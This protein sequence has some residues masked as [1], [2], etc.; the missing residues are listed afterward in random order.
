[1]I[2]IMK[3]IFNSLLLFAAVVGFTS[4]NDTMDD[5]AVIDAMYA[6]ASDV[7]VENVV[8][9]AVDYQTISATATVSA[10]EGLLEVGVEYAT[11]A[12]FSDAEA[13]P[14]A[15]LGTAVSVTATGLNG[16][17]EYFVRAYAVT[18]NAGTVVS[19]SVTVK[20]PKIPI[21]DVNGMYTVTEYSQS[22]DDGLF[23]PAAE[24]YP[25]LVQFLEGSE[26][27]VE[28]INLWGFGGTIYGTWDAENSVIIVPTKQVLGVH[29]SYGDVWA[30]A[31]NASATAY[32]QNIIFSFT[33]IG[34]KMTCTPFQ[35]Q[36]GAGDFG[37]YYVSMV[38]NE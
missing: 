35:A 34:G 23:Y 21:F 31:L 30:N 28:I 38:H 12:D 16:E 9:T 2:K 14:T 27:E 20:T 24:T 5:K 1:M 37:V 13:I 33:S 19:E 17:T 3:K 22:A 10:V 15:E 11:V 29:P 4:C 7:K 36:C 25:M 6:G 32:A 18:K 8:A 26:T